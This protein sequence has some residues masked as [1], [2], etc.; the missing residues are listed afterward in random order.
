MSDLFEELL[1]EKQQKAYYKFSDFEYNTKG[2][3]R[4]LSNIS[5]LDYLIKGFELGCMTIWTGVTN[6]GKSTVLT[7]IAKESL[8]QNEKVFFF[9]GEQTKDDF[10]NNLYKQFAPREKIYQKQY[11]NTNISDYYVSE[12]YSKY[13]SLKYDDK[14]FVYNNDII[15]TID[16]F[17]IIICPIFTREFI[18]IRYSISINIR[19]I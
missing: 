18:L 16:I 1:G 12:A 9:N 14:I 13:L 6:M 17:T 10:K 4:I 2:K 3:E 5:Q 8:V 15:K 11:K 7:K 19:E